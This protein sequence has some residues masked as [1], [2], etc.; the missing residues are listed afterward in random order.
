MKKVG[1]RPKGAYIQK[2]DWKETYPLTQNWKSELLFS[3]DEQL[4]FVRMINNYFYW[5]IHRKNL[6]AD[7]ARDLET[8]LLEP[9]KGGQN[10]LRKTQN[11]LYQWARIMEGPKG[12][13]SLTVRMKHE[14][15]EDGMVHTENTFRTLKKDV[16]VITEHVM[17]SDKKVSLNLKSKPISA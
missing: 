16:F 17:E 4:F 8:D 15:P 13:D 10:L 5:I 2:T 3:S 14:Y 7:V 6:D 9:D 11:H 12:N 1:K